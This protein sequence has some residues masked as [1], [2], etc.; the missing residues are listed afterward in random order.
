MTKVAQRK[1]TLSGGLAGFNSS[2]SRDFA[3]A[4]QRLFERNTF[5]FS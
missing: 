3:R 5:D 1:I 2:Q 4:R